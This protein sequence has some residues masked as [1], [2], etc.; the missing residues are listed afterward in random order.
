VRVRGQLGQA[1]PRAR[2]QLIAERSKAR[3]ARI[4]RA[5]AMKT[6]IE[7]AERVRVERDAHGAGL[8]SGAGSSVH[9][10]GMACAGAW[11]IAIK[12]THF[13]TVL[14]RRHEMH[15]LADEEHERRLRAA[16]I[17]QKC[18]RTW[19]ET[20]QLHR[21]ARAGAIILRMLR[22]NVLRQRARRRRW[23]AHV[24]V[25]ALVAGAQKTEMVARVQ[26]VRNAAVKLQRWWRR[27]REARKWALYGPHLQWEREMT[28]AHTLFKE[29]EGTKAFNRLKKRGLLKNQTALNANAKE[30]CVAN[31]FVPQVGKD[32]RHRLLVQHYQR[33]RLQWHQVVREYL[34]RD[35]VWLALFHVR[36]QALEAKTH[37]EEEEHS[38]L[39][40]EQRALEASADGMPSPRRFPRSPRRM[41]EV[42]H[43]AATQS[44]DEWLT[45]P[46]PSPYGARAHAL[47][48]A[49]SVSAEMPPKELYEIVKDLPP[50]PERPYLRVFL[51]KAVLYALFLDAYELVTPA[52]P[53]SFRSR[54]KVFL[55]NQLRRMVMINALNGSAPGMGMRA[56]AQPIAQTEV[57]NS[58]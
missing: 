53:A 1:K 32:V 30:N 43:S 10:E 16:R 47:A 42:D 33:Q 28:H 11:A 18:V 2:K 46:S 38:G 36:K 49:S 22:L 21:E 13:L 26:R 17:I 37:A 31:V 57:P 50:R 9:T 25:S 20:R 45:Q 56:K 29:S 58:Q 14:R 44:G 34:H 27:C 40:R 7:G 51:P 41:A 4:A 5:Q 12:V 52:P 48:R 3:D 35:R 23:A 15:L 54:V 39:L 8:G 6:L 19:L 55:G 24:L